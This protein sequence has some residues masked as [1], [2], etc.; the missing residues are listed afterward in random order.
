[1]VTDSRQDKIM[2]TPNREDDRDYAA[3]T[4]PNKGNAWTV[5]QVPESNM[6]Y[7]NL[8]M[9]RTT[10]WVLSGKQLTGYNDSHRHTQTSQTTA[11]L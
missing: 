7:D 1:M 4:P 9:L 10:K 8:L 6:S 3:Q 2:I 11:G 5:M